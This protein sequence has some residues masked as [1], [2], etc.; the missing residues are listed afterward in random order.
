MVVGRGHS[1]LSEACEV[2]L[3]GSEVGRVER[4]YMNL[5]LTLDKSR[6]ADLLDIHLQR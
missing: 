5:R 4:V 6:L 1:I 2:H 3:R